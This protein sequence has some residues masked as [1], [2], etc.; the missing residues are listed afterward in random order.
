MGTTY[1]LFK[2]VFF[3]AESYPERVAVRTIGKTLTYGQLQKRVVEAAEAFYE[4]GID[5]HSCVAL[6]TDKSLPALTAGLALALIGCK[7]VYASREALNNPLLF[8]THIVHDEPRKSTFSFKSVIMDEAWHS[9]AGA[10]P[11]LSIG[12]IVGHSSPRDILVVGQSS[13]TTG[14]PKF[15]PITAEN[16]IK[17]INPRYL[18]DPSP[19]PVIASVFQVLHAAIYFVLLRVF[20]KGG[21]VVFGVNKAHWLEA[22]VTMLMAS[23]MH[24]AQ[25]IEG[26]AGQASGK[27]PRIW[28]AGSPVYPAF[29]DLALNHFGEVI[30]A[31]GAM[32]ASIACHKAIKHRMA[33]GE[34]VGVGPAMHDVVLEVVDESGR[35]VKT[36]DV[37]EVRYK[38]PL[39]V[40][41]Y[42]GDDD[43][44]RTFFRNGWFY[45][46]DTGY[47]NST[48]QL[49]I[50]GRVNDLLNIGGTKLNAAT[51]DGVLQSAPGIGDGACFTEPGPSG[52]EQLSVVVV[53]P[54]AGGGRNQIAGDL[55]KR[56]EKRFPHPVVPT[57]VYFAETIPR[58]DNGKVLRAT[59]RKKALAGE[60]TKITV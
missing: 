55:L 47:L 57:C 29:L 40:T 28:L 48:R 38:T 20:A 33:E 54:N 60:W 30:N 42:I 46:G 16:A 11:S 4:R 13:G 49:F 59:A 8:I 21:T 15:F 26:R 5:K 32:E 53:V 9:G 12:R 17:R 35:P 7:W 36:G 27:I 10:K 19:K 22:G 58:N 1:N 6:A 39:L 14:E 51:V 43:A 34:V 23:P 41:G 2:V 3:A 45:P 25:I 56:L 31:Y 24:A 18:L 44:T 50:T 37:G 52:F